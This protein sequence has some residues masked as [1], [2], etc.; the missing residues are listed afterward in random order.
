MVAFGK[1]VSKIFILGIHH[2]EYILPV[3]MKSVKMTILLFTVSLLFAEKKRNSK[4]STTC[5][6]IFA[7][8]GPKNIL[9]HVNHLVWIN[10]LL[11]NLVT[12]HTWNMDY[13]LLHDSVSDRKQSLHKLWPSIKDWKWGSIS[14]G[15]R[16]QGFLTEPKPSIALVGECCVLTFPFNNSPAGWNQTENVQRATPRKVPGV[17]LPFHNKY[18]HQ[19]CCPASISPQLSVWCLGKSAGKCRLYKLLCKAAVVV[20]FCPWHLSY[21]LDI[22]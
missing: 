6:A 1:V 10:N 9:L 17:E 14:T 8:K 16:E 5:T 12:T 13:A 21:Y 7:C 3:Q 11:T 20:L 22:L 18:S 4:T 2:R 15:R 19:P